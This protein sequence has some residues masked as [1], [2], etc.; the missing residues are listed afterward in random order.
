MKKILLILI[1]V[2]AL[3]L[4]VYRI[5]DFPAGPNLDEV[6][7][8]Y[9]AYSI[10]KTGRDE[11]GEFL[12]LSP[13]AFGDFR[14]PLYTYLIIPSVAFLGLNEFAIRFP[15]ALLG[16]LAVVVLYLL[17]KELFKN[18]KLA[19]VSAFLL[20]INPWHLSL[21]RGA[22]EASLHVF[23]FPLG[24]LLFLKGLKSWKY[25]LVSGCVLGLNLFSYYAPR[26]FTPL[27]VLFLVFFYR[28]DFFKEKKNLLFGALFGFFVCLSVLALLAGGK[29][30]V[31]DTSLLNPAGG[32]QR[33]AARQY[34]AVWLGFYP[35]VEKAFNNKLMLVSSDF[36][37][38]YLDYFSFSFLFSRGPL[39]ATYGMVPGRGVL[40]LFELPLIIYAI[41][42]VVKSKE[43]PGL[44]ILLL[45]FVSPLAAAL[46]KGERAA[47][48][49][50]PMLPLWQIVSSVGAV[51][52]WEYS[53]KKVSRKL[54]L[55]GFLVISV[56]SLAFFLEDYFYHAPIQ[57]APNMSYGWRQISDFLRQNSSNYDR[58][59][60]SKNLSEPQIAVA[61]FLKMDPLV[62]QQD[63][64]SW[65][66]YESRGLLFVDQLP[67]YRLDKFE[68]RNFHFPEDQKLPKT[69]FIGKL[70][71]FASVEGK[72]EK[73]VYYP[74]P[75]QKVAFKLVSFSQGDSQ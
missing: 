12:P 48:R 74:G 16:S 39:E 14:A 57:N 61:Y 54:F 50:V 33:V 8:G 10:L 27:V 58:V 20:A 55:A 47:N 63:S 35:M 37:K 53:K 62:V 6:S 67:E 25:L 19:L 68:F 49:A 15:A 7:Q 26:F 24:L 38:Q 40:Y 66:E 3:V 5:A 23:F 69:L 18:E 44:L 2:L 52:L 42:L 28:K 72:V 17:T 36:Y 13:R 64:P 21:S 73:I 46:A 70:E 30:R 51:G 41:Y 59:V 32:W 34:E 22:F 11:W 75:D 1:F 60:V 29:T 65:L 56:L 71:D 31:S 45:L 9:S 4:R 43:K